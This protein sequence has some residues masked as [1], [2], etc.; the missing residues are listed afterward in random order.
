MASR[1]QIDR[2]SRTVERVASALNPPGVCYV[3]L[4]YNETA[5]DALAAYR[6]EFGIAANPARVVFNRARPGDTRAACKT[7]GMHDLYCLGP[8]D[9]RLLLASIDGKTRGIPSATKSD[10]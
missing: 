1:S 8:S 3:P 5:A 9:I 2:I 7:S 4:Y 6:Q 10:R